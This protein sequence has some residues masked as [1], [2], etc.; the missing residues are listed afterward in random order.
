MADKEQNRLSDNLKRAA[1][2]HGVGMVASHG[3][4]GLMVAVGF[5][6]AAVLKPLVQGTT[7]SLMNYCYD[8]M[9]KRRLSDRENEKVDML[10]EESLRTFMEMAEKD[11]VTAIEMQIAPSQLENAY[12]VSEELMLAAIRQS[13]NKKVK[14]L[15]RYY[16]KTF[17]EGKIDWQDMHQIITMAGALTYRQVVMIRLIC[18]GFNGISP[19]MFIT[20]SSAC[21]DINRM[22]EYGLWMT[23]MALFKND[24]SARI[25]LKL[26]KPTEYAKMVCEALMLEKLS[27]DDI[28]RTIENLAL[29]E[30]GEPAEGITKEDYESSNT[31]IEYNEET[32]GLS[33][34]Q[35]RKD[36]AK[37][38]ATSPE[39]LDYLLKGNN[40]LNEASGHD[41]KGNVMLAIDKVMEAL[42][43]LKKCKSE[44][45]YKSNVDEAL[46]KLKTYF[47]EGKDDGGGLRILR[48]KRQEYEKTLSGLKSEY[49]EICQEYLML[50]EM[51]DEGF[52]DEFQNKEMESWFKKSI[53]EKNG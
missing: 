31:W 13:Q 15:G 44:L 46:K 34:K 3:F 10:A 16:G 45:L 48:G 28:K 47:E 12:E 29:S 1:L 4:A 24:A 9:I 14:I 22:R 33:V 35:G 51:K 43:V 40:I 19:E 11:G 7:I 20:N 30:Q 6:E 52:D 17:Y 50:A 27:D 8:D 21:I 41:D 2:A 53:N 38:V 42:Q 39:D 32:E 37:M 25:Q 49:L 5:P 18:D 26:L 23:E 36:T